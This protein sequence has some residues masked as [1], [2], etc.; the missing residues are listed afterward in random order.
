LSRIVAAIAAV[1]LVTAPA[2][3]LGADRNAPTSARSATHVVARPLLDGE[4]VVEIDRVRA[5]HHLPLLRTATGLAASAAA[6]SREMI[7]YG[8]FAHESYGGGAFWRRIERYYPSANFHRWFVGETLLWVSPDVDAQTAVQ[9]WLNS[10]PHRKILLDGALR[11]FGV[12]ALH[13]TTAPGTFKGLEATI[14]TADFG[15]RVR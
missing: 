15:V 14:I 7:D 8:F 6:H 5:Q 3:A 12:S 11:Q 1:A 4:I 10:P 9:D 13:A 2:L